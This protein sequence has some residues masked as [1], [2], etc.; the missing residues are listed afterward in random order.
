MT[1]AVCQ[2]N[3][4][5]FMVIDKSF[6]RCQTKDFWEFYAGDLSRY[7]DL[8]EPKRLSFINTKFTSQVLVTGAFINR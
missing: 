5:L 3:T 1:M 6:K 4:F 8:N 7:L 2:S